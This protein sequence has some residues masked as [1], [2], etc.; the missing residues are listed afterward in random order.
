MS[1]RTGDE[2]AAWL[3]LHKIEHDRLLALGVTPAQ[4]K[5]EARKVRDLKASSAAGF[6]LW[7]RSMGITE[8]RLIDQKVAIWEGMYTAKQSGDSIGH[9]AWVL[10][11]F[12]TST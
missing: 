4:R 9:G 7:A 6:E 10:L 5:R 8:K 11:D 3:R 12:S 2:K 1:R